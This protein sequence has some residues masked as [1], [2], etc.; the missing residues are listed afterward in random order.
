MMS[1]IPHHHTHTYT[2]ML[3]HLQT[4]TLLT[5]QPSQS[6][7]MSS[8]L[9]LSRPAERPPGARRGPWSCPNTPNEGLG[10]FLALLSLPVYVRGT[11]AT[12]CADL[13]VR[14]AGSRCGCS[15]V[16]HSHATTAYPLP[17]HYPG[18]PD[19]RPQL[20]NWLP[21][22]SSI[23]QGHQQSTSDDAHLCVCGQEGMQRGSSEFCH[24]HTHTNEKLYHALHTH[25]HQQAECRKQKPAENPDDSLS[26]LCKGLTRVCSKSQSTCPNFAA[27]M[28]C[29]KQNHTTE[30][31]GILRG[32]TQL[33][34]PVNNF[35]TS[36]SRTG[37]FDFGFMRACFTNPAQAKRNCTWQSQR[38]KGF[39][40]P[41]LCINESRKQ[42][43]F[44]AKIDYIQERGSRQVYSMTKC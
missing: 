2:C 11:S 37:A 44:E 25:T 6:C 4:H 28:I 33:Y 42:L 39:S 23:S 8:L 41:S 15:A 36:R 34:L 16:A 21:F 9:A 12:Q 35:P 43:R 29:A 17:P 27:K 26:R 3:A 31:G 30:L 1:W 14:L 19:T 32:R 13:G 20:H 7:L 18:L 5:A 10:K 22:T 24:Q 40:S 38:K